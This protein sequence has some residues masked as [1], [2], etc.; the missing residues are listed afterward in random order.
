[1]YRAS[2][3]HLISVRCNILQYF[4]DRD[5]CTKHNE[6]IWCSSFISPKYTGH[7]FARKLEIR[8]F[9]TGHQSVWC[10]INYFL[11]PDCLVYRQGRTI[12]K[13]CDLCLL[14]PGHLHDLPTGSVKV[15]C[16][17]PERKVVSLSHSRVIPKT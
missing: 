6:N 8:F 1:M 5:F 7:I 14:L 13:I 12:Q 17:P 3:R 11:T 9:H 10:L 2:D 16:S 4:F 15:E